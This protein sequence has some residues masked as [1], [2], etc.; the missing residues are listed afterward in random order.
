L[1]NRDRASEKQLILP[2]YR[3]ETLIGDREEDAPVDQEES[4]MEKVLERENLKRAL[5]QV[6]RNKGTAG[7]DG[8]TIEDLTPYLKKQETSK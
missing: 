1:K 6:K 8:M 5:K 4:L 2:L 3:D 7:V